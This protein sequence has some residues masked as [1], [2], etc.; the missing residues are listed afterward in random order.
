MATNLTPP[1]VGSPEWWALR[2]LRRLEARAHDLR[3][4]DDYYEGRQPLAFAS[5]KFNEA[6][7]DRFPEFTS[8]FCALVVDGLAERLEVQGFR[9]GD[10]AGDADVWAMW[11]ENDLDAGSQ[12]AHTEALIKGSAY[13]L[14]EP[15]REA[16]PIITIEDPLD[17]IVEHEPKDRRRRR[18][19]L[20]RWVDDEGALV[21]VVY[22][23]EGVFKYRSSKRWQPEHYQ[24]FGDFGRPPLEPGE[25]TEGPA[26]VWASAG[27]ERYQPRGDEEWPLPNPMGVVP[28]VELPNRP[29]LR[30]GGRSEIKAVRSNQDA[31]NKYRTDALITS[32]FAAYPQRYLLNYEPETDA[33]TGRPREPF[34]TA[35]DRLWTVPPPDP[36]NP[37][38]PEPKIGSLP[39][40]DLAPYSN[41]IELEVG[42][43]SSISGMPYHYFLS[44]PQT[45]PP[46]GESLK[47]S[48]ARLT[49]KV[50]RAELYLGDG[51]EETMRVALLARNDLRGRLRT[52]E[53]IWA[54][55]ETRN[56][57]TRT[58]AV[59]KLHAEGIIDDELSW[60]MLGLSPEQISRV[61]G[62][63]PLEPATLGLLEER[64]EEAGVGSAA[65]VV[66]ELLA[67][68]VAD[69]PSA[70]PPEVVPAPIGGRFGT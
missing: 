31:V 9:F 59:V 64:L 61:R 22:L 14:V 7:G 46:S 20:K 57:A 63:R 16:I 48:E 18:A 67:E 49:R 23:P 51:W 37:D 32:E 66:R 60:E 6:F 11:Q 15:R 26:Q 34:R 65:Q 10:P 62:R 68:L 4:W 29:R 39:A 19:G 8:N 45:V 42:H 38:A 12:L 70:P 52:A 25:F 36:D 27:F 24:L 44:T 43:L 5:Q 17:A 21:L 33:D 55:S 69:H 54:D 58:D 2:L 3:T 50:G 1:A 53:T 47:S 35:I 40:A 28:L 41:M 13:A 56:E 30:K